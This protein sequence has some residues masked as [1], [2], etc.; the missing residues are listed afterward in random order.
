MPSANPSPP[1]PPTPLTD[2]TRKPLLASVIK[3]GLDKQWTLG[4]R[5]GVGIKQEGNG[6]PNL[7]FA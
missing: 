3:G 4:I 7:S 1:D 2:D 6:V 5:D